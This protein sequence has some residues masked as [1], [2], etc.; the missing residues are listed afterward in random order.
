MNIVIA[1]GG[2]AGWLAAY[3]FSEYQPSIHNITVIES[4][5]IGIIGAGEGSTGLLYDLLAGHLFQGSANVNDF[6]DFTDG[7]QKFGIDFKNWTPAG[8]SFFAPI[9][10]SPHFHR[11]PDLV[12]NYVLSHFDKNDIHK[13]S[14]IGQGYTRKKMPRGPFALH[15]DGTKAGGYFKSLLPNV[16][17]IDAKIDDVVLDSK[18]NISTLTLSNGDIVVGDL[19]IDATGFA[20]V[21]MKELGVG[22]E[23]YKEN[24]PV[25]RAMPFVLEYDEKEDFP[26][27]LTTAH[28]LSSGWMWQ[29]PLQTRMGCGYVYS[30]KFISDEDAQKEIETLLGRSIKPIKFISFESGRSEQLWANNCVAVGLAGAFSEPLEATSIHTTILQLTVLAVNHLTETPETTHTDANRSSYNR[31]FTRLY[32][33]Y[34]D[35]LVMHYQG[36]RTDSDF[37]KHISSGATTTPFVEEIKKLSKTHLPTYIHYE[38]YWSS[39]SALWNWVL[40]GLGVLTE[41]VALKELTNTNRLEQA[42]YEYAEFMGYYRAMDFGDGHPFKIFKTNLAKLQQLPNNTTPR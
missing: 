25:D 9:D 41:E 37:W 35:F 26:E 10:A 23:S 4:S 30:S 13:A 40:A 5:E 15:F 8:D 27:P 11:N 19:F 39:S 12:F 3:I 24:L 20:R 38:E 21:L 7:T 2:T 42:S 17:C 34:R 1:G 33:H 14:H 28:A 31:K 22:W 29:I 16:S 6:I 32:D 36:G 18:G